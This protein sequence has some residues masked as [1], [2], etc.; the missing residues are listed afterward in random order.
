METNGIDSPEITLQIHG[1]VIFD[2]GAKTNQW[3]RAIF[4]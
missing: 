1:Q 4:R 3:E 2:N